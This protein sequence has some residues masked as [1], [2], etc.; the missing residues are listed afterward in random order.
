M[1][2]RAAR[3]EET[4]QNKRAHL[5]RLHVRHRRRRGRH[6]ELHL[7]GEQIDKARAAAFIWHVHD[8]DA[9]HHRQQLGPLGNV[10]RRLARERERILVTLLPFDQMRE[11]IAGG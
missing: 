10:E 8:V 3:P 5:A 1:K 9:R 6:H 2:D 4:P 11:Q 7:A